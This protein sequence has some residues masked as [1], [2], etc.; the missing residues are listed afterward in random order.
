MPLPK[1][2]SPA[3]LPSSPT[4]IAPGPLAIP[5]A[6]ATLIRPGPTAADIGTA[7]PMNSP[8]AAASGYISLDAANLAAIS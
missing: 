2:D 6:L 3:I 5:T 4:P 1:A 8:V 7:N